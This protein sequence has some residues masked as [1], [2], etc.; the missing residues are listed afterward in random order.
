[1][2]NAL[3]AMQAIGAHMRSNIANLYLCRFDKEEEMLHFLSTEITA[4]RIS[5]SRLNLINSNKRYSFLLQIY[6]RATCANCKTTIPE[7]ASRPQRSAH[8]VRRSPLAVHRSTA[9][10]TDSLPII[11]RFVIFEHARLFCI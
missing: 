7:S 3:A 5:I 2:I 6:C 9:K 10:R 8:L 1:M 11:C 4:H